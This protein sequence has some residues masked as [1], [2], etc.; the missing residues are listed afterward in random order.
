MSKLIIV[1]G[2]DCTGK[3]TLAKFIAR[4]LRAAYFHAVGKKNLHQG[5]TEYHVNMVENALVCLD[6]SDMNVVFDRHWPSEVVY[7]QIL[8]V[9]MH[10]R[11]YEIHKVLHMLDMVKPTHELHYIFCTSNEAHNRQMVDQTDHPYTSEEFAQIY[12]E[13]EALRSR[14]PQNEFNVHYYHLETH[15][16]DIHGYLKSKGLL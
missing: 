7:G 9:A 6:V 12:G 8:R 4:E 2:A 10:D 1:E 13:Y 14:L 15:G 5:M 3:S 11:Y 16:S